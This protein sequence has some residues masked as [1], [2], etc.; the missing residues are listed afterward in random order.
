MVDGAAAAVTV[1]NNCQ[2]A[3]GV[4]RAQGDGTD[5]CEDEV[6]AATGTAGDISC[7]NFFGVGAGELNP[8]GNEFTEAATEPDMVDRV[9]VTTPGTARAAGGKRSKNC[10]ANSLTGESRFKTAATAATKILSR[11]CP[12]SRLQ[13]IR[14]IHYL[15]PLINSTNFLRV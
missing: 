15:H 14:T 1:Q 6:V 7:V 13:L 8:A 2:D 12:F 10:D 4:P 5:F 11:L 9:I 3:Q